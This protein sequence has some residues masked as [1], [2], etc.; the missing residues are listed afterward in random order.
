MSAI[1]HNFLKENPQLQKNS[2]KTKIVLLLSLLMMLVEVFYGF[3]TQSMALLSDGWHLAADTVALMITVLAYRLADTPE[4]CK[5]FNFGGG[6][7]IPLGG[8]TSALL[9]IGVVSTLG[10]ESGVRLFT[11]HL[12]DVVPAIVVTAVGLIVNI[13]SAFI[14]REGHHHHHHGDH[15]HHHHVHT[16]WNLR[17]AYLH[18]ISD[19]VTSLFALLAL[20]LT[21]YTGIT[22]FDPLMGLVGSI[23]IFIWG[24]RLIKSTG[25]ELLDGHARGID[26]DRVK[27]QIEQTGVQVLDLHIWK[28]APSALACELVVLASSPKGLQFYKNLLLKNFKLHHV[29]IEERT[30]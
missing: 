13:F 12:I 22:W 9:L 3:K 6:K 11:P 5:R 18:I 28:I 16:D 21:Y 2:Q 26:Y 14:L 7:I 4:W 1:E 27:T 29:V 15:D 10:Y 20:T 8:Y 23:I 24:I 30:T 17:G 19:I 25:W